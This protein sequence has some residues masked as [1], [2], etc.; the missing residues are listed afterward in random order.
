MDY[1]PRSSTALHS[2][3]VKQTVLY[4]DIVQDLATQQIWARVDFQHCSRPIHIS[5]DLR[6]A[7]RTAI[8]RR[9]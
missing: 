5:F 3:I 8:S 4:G 9:N 6:L 2:L 1:N 7:S